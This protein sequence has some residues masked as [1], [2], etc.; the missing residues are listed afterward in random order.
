MVD[1]E[2][3]EFKLFGHPTMKKNGEKISFSFAKVNAFLYYLLVNKV[4]TRDEIAGLLWP[5]K[6]ENS[7]KKNLRNAIYQVNKVIGED[8]IYSKNNKRIELNSTYTIKC[9][10]DFFLKGDGFGLTYYKDVFLKGFFLK[11]SEEYDVWVVKM[12]NH[13]EQLFVKKYAE[14]IID[15]IENCRYDTVET[16]IQKLIAIDEFEEKHYQLL[17]NFYFS[18][19]R[20][21][22]VVET[23][24]Q[25]VDLLERELN[26]LPNKETRQIYEKTIHIQS[27]VRQA[28]DRSK[29]GIFYGRYEELAAL[30]A[31][32]LRVFQGGHQHIV[33]EGIAGVGKSALVNTVLQRL[34][35][36]FFMETIICHRAEVEYPFR[37]FKRL[38]DVLEDI[39][40][41]LGIVTK[42]G[43]NSLLKS[44][45]EKSVVERQTIDDLEL[46]LT[47]ILSN[48]EMKQPIIIVMDDIHFLDYESIKL[49]NRLLLNLS[50]KKILFILTLQPYVNRTLDTFLNNIAFHNIAVK[51]EMNTFSKAEVEQYIRKQ[52]SEVVTSDIVDLIYEHS[53]GLPFFVNEYLNLATKN[54]PINRITFKMQEFLKEQFGQF[55]DVQMDVLILLSYFN[56]FATIETLQHILNYDIDVVEVAID[57]AMECRLVVESDHIEG[58]LVFTHQKYKEYLYSKQTY[59]K[60]RMIHKKI[61]LFLEQYPQE[62]QSMA[63]IQDIIMHYE[64]ANLNLKS[65]YYWLKKLEWTLAAQH[66]IFPVF[67]KTQESFRDLDFSQMSVELDCIEQALSGLKKHH[68]NEIEY[69]DLVTKYH[70]LKGKYSI[71]LGRYSEG[72]AYIQQVI[73]QEELQH[74]QNYLFEAYRQMIYYYL[75]VDDSKQLILF[76]KKAMELAVEF[77]DYQQMGMLL[78]IEGVYYMMIGEFEKAEK[79]LH[80]SIHIYSITETLFQ[81]YQSN[82]AA[83]YDYLA[84][85]CRIQEEYSRAITYHTSAIELADGQFNQAGKVVFL[86][87]R[88]TTYLQSKKYEKAS[89]DFEVAKYYIRQIHSLWKEVQLNILHALCQYYLGNVSVALEV[90]QDYMMDYDHT[91][92]HDKGFVFYLA[93]ILKRDGVVKKEKHSNLLNEEPNYYFNEAK[94]RL[95]QYRDSYLLKS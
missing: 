59:T 43:W 40:I 63:W 86:L 58:S 27:K 21:S 49:L 90:L 18:T 3:L 54:I 83:A 38:M 28:G 50:N 70:L 87:N 62:K 55:D 41:S 85:I 95:N 79:Q 88:G 25:L 19:N 94:K 92:E 39:A 31:H 17:M 80:E 64:S 1:K 69:L 84:E 4:T 42:K 91:N 35:Q 37:A 47:E 8:F 60:K 73:S 9:D 65:V 29:K 51:I 6:T 53:E 71:R 46:A 75:E 77:N 11:D 30:E 82:I 72:I 57:K 5:D 34:T 12:R 33:L 2:L 89:A 78:R 26:V 52:M 48:I 20:H 68:A 15:D 81:K 61:A 45:F 7:A 23:Y 14:K 10:V 44:L 24:Y 32:T 36:P 56:K 16:D 74:Q 13:F 22:K 76:V 67:D 66:D 93:Y